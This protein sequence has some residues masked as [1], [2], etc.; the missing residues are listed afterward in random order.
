[1]RTRLEISAA[2]ACWRRLVLLGSFGASQDGGGYAAPFF[3]QSCEALA[4]QD[5]K[6]PPS[7]RPRRTG[8]RS[9]AA[10]AAPGC[11]LLFAN[12]HTVVRF[13]SASSSALV[14]GT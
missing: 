6:L 12:R 3:I 11:Y 8:P 7:P 13:I 4:R 2:R 10:Q 5:K 1:M 14:T 9:Q